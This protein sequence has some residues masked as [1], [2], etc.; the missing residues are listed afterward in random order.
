MPFLNAKC[1]RPP[2]YDSSRA[3][4]DIRIL[5]YIT[6]RKNGSF[7]ILT[8]RS[9][10]L[11]V[12]LTEAPDNF[13]TTVLYP[14]VMAVALGRALDRH[15]DRIR[16]HGRPLDLS[17]PQPRWIRGIA[18]KTTMVQSPTNEFFRA[19]ARSLAM[20]YGGINLHKAYQAQSRLARP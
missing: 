18:D 20:D 19:P 6:R 11:S 10:S 3:N 17:G 16:G 7:C 2:W 9:I 14:A 4:R 8:S 15:P 5:I 12:L 13:P 1:C